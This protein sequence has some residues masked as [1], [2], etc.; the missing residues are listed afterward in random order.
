M[1]NQEL[2]TILIK[3]LAL[4]TLPEEAQDEVISK[5]G[6]NILKSLTRRIFERLSSEDRKKFEMISKTGD[7][8]RIQEFLEVAVPDMHNIMEEEIKKTIRLYKEKEEG[9]TE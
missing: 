5:L 3:E 1:R 6:D 7:D 2:R 8:E 9:A 4:E